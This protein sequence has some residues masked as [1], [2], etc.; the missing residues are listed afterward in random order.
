MS[1]ASQ[2][3]PGSLTAELDELGITR[4][5][6]RHMVERGQ[7]VELRCEMPKCYYHKGRR[8]F[9]VKRHP[10]AQWQLS[11]DHYP[12]LAR[13]GGRLD[14]WNVRLG[15]VLCNREDYGWRVRI[16]TMLEKGMSLEA[17]AER[18]NRIGVRRP[19]GSPS[20]TAASVRRAFVS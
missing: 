7:I 8:S 9:E 2:Q 19:H 14:P 16:R 10:P 18:L 6:V 4:G 13:D 15:H 3:K 11:V 17:I 1:D 12:T 5:I 20:W